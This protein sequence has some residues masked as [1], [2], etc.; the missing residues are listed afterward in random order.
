[1]KKLIFILLVFY[2]A[3][4]KTST[5]KPNVRTN[6]KIA[7]FNVQ[8]FNDKK[9][10]KKDV[11]AVVASIITKFDIIAFQEIQG[12]NNSTIKKL[13]KMVSGSHD[14][15]VSPKLGYS[16][17]YKER[18]AFFYDR[19]VLKHI[20]NHVYRDSLDEFSRDPYIGL[21]EVIGKKENIIFIDI[22]TPPR[23]ATREIRRLPKVIA[24]S[25]TKL[26]NTGLILL[27]DFNADCAYYNEKNYQEVFP[28]SSYIWAIGNDKA[29]SVVSGC[30]FD[31]IVLTRNLADNFVSAGVYDFKL[32]HG[33]SLKQALKVSD[34]YPVFVELK[35]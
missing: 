12:K 35:F 29:T 18:Y 13:D 31:R 4:S 33:L 3:C 5:Q 17:T 26:P 22:H 20:S 14:Y 32:K 15:I 2:L 30:T 19:K 8:F 34:H 6:I 7:S 21:F 28:A 16:K 1:M 10:S 27:G 23:F 9:N 25:I 11:M 24:D